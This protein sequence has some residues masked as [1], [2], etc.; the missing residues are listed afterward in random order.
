M[1]VVVS[2]LMAH[3]QQQ[4]FVPA[5]A[6]G[7]VQ[8]APVPTGQPVSVPMAQPVQ[9]GMAPGQPMMGMA[10]G[11]PV[12]MGTA[13]GQPMIT[14]PP[15]QYVAGPQGG[16]VFMPQPQVNV[17]VDQSSIGEQHLPSHNIALVMVMVILCA[18]FNITSLM[19]GIPAIILAVMVRMCLRPN[20]IIINFTL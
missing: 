6:P 12:M 9:M 4:F 11:Q 18:F 1:S 15:V 19:F 2:K 7:Q 20:L 16:M 17:N 8:Q 13:P 3:Q 14:Q 5:A 10:P